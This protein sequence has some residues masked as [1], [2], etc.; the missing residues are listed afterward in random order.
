MRCG[1]RVAVV[2]VLAAALSAC[3]QPAATP[4]VLNAEIPLG[5][6]TLKVRHIERTSLDSQTALEDR[7]YA[8]HV[9]CFGVPSIRNVTDRLLYFDN[10]LERQLSL[11]DSDGDRFRP[12]LAEDES[13]YAFRFDQTTMPSHDDRFWVV[14]FVVPEA[15]RDFTLEV[16]NPDPQERQPVV[17]SV[18]LGMPSG[19]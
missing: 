5:G 8:V 7:A 6:M 4:Y 1:K 11:V 16:R 17:A 2:A 3:R 14:T 10:F 18:H 12:T 19:R 15:S 13:S 9:S